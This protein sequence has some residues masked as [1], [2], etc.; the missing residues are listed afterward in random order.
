MKASVTTAG[1]FLLG[2]GEQGCSPSRP[3]HRET[4][5]AD[6]VVVGAGL[7]GLMAARELVKAGVGRS[8]SSRRASGA[9]GASGSR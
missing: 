7:A 4:K 2:C 9:S 1:T 3:V 8:L 5:R 6:V